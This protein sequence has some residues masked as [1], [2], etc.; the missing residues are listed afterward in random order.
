MDQ[1]T[2]SPPSLSVAEL[3]DG[4]GRAHRRRRLFSAACSA[5]KLPIKHSK[6]LYLLCVIA[7]SFLLLK[8]AGMPKGWLDS[9]YAACSLVQLATIT[10]L[11]FALFEIPLSWCRRKTVHYEYQWRLRA[12]E[13]RWELCRRPASELAAEDD[14]AALEASSGAGRAGPARRR[15]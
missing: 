13:L 9:V 10:L 5:T 14:R 7:A 8:L 4:I 12:D 3:R 6:P 11:A 15:L 2:S 1:P